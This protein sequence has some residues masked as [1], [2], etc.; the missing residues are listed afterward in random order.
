MS[1]LSTLIEFCNNRIKGF[2]T[3]QDLGKILP[4]QHNGLCIFV[5]DNKMF[6]V[7]GDKVSHI[8]AEGKYFSN[9]EILKR[10]GFLYGIKLE[11][12]NIFA[13]TT[14]ARKMKQLAQKE[15]EKNGN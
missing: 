6:F 11:K 9:I 15:G 10:I 14:F 2:S 5:E 1:N 8:W 7:K 13:L 3:L 12:E 4:L